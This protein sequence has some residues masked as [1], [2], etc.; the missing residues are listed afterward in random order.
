VLTVEENRGFDC[1]GR[2]ANQ[3]GG[4]VS[5]PLPP[6]TTFAKSEEDQKSDIA[7]LFTY[8]KNLNELKKNLYN[9]FKRGNLDILK[10]N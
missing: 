3:V 7:N 8:L 9:Y 1:Q 10:S 4:C 2:F 6:G 5:V